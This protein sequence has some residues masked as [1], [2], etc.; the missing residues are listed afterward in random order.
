MI[1]YSLAFLW[2][3]TALTSVWFGYE[4]GVQILSQTNIPPKWFDLLIYAR[5]ILDA[6]IGVWLLTGKYL[7]FNAYLQIITIVGFSILISLLVPQFW[8]HPF[9]PVTKNVPIVVLIVLMIEKISKK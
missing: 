9:G 4:Q 8:L 3:F 5:A 6:F 7:K 2:L 1:R